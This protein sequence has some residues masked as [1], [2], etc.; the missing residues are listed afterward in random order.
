VGL[1]SSDAVERRKAWRL[2]MLLLVA[3][4]PT[5]VVGLLMKHYVEQTKTNPQFVGAME[6]LTGLYLA[7]S[8]FRRDG[9]KDRD[10]AL[11]VA[12]SPD[13]AGVRGAPGSVAVGFDDRFRAAPGVRGP[14]G[15]GLHLPAR[16]PGDRRGGRSRDPVRAEA[17]WPGFFATPDFAR[18]L[19]GAAVAGSWAT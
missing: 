18:Y 13:G 19:V 14:V 11:S 8:Y 16:D 6:I 1:V 2:A 15:G 9:H 5:G 7:V 3:T 10:A 12:F 4:I 17:Q